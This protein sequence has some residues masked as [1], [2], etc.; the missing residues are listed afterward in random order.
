M[1]VRITTLCEN[2]VGME[3]GRGDFLAESGLSLFIETDDISILFDTGKRIATL[4]NADTIGIDLGKVNKI[5]LSHSHYDH[6]GG[7]REVLRRIKQEKIEIIAH[8]HIWSI[9][10]NRREG[11][12]DKFM[13][14]PFQRQELENFGAFFNLTTKPVRIT[15]NIMTS[16][17]IPM[18]TEFEQTESGETR[19]LIEEDG[20]LKPDGLLD[21]QALVINGE[22][23]LIVVTGCAHRGI[24]N[25]LYQAQK[26]TSVNK[27]YAVIGGSHLVD[28]S[29]ERIW[30]TIAALKDL[31]VKVLG[32]CHCTS[33][34][35]MVPIAQEFGD[36]FF[37]NNAGSVVELPKE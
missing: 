37:F 31:D 9:R 23:G 28:T 25:T 35:A 8:P 22:Q 11:K 34:P 26:I 1:D 17:E 6:T 16:G 18:V 27:I 13:G 24:I 15:E 10:Y 30:L 5:V 12:P 29:E 19:R 33:L 21:D 32:L 14:V 7:L 2:K 4:H 36:R 3:Y 20:T